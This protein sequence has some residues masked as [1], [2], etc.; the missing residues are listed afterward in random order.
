MSKHLSEASDGDGDLGHESVGSEGT[1][2]AAAETSRDMVEDGFDIATHGGGRLESVEGFDIARAMTEGFES[3]LMP[4]DAAMESLPRSCDLHY[5]QTPETVCGRDDRVQITGTS[6]I[7]WRMICQL[8]I[9][10]ADNLQSRCTGWF[11][12][13]RTVVTAGHCVFSKSAGG[14]AKRIEVIPGMNGSQRPFGSAVGTSFRSVTGW[15]NDQSPDYDYGAIILPN[16]TLGN[17]VGWFGFANLSDSSLKELLVNSSG[18][19][20]D[21]PFGTQWYNAGRVTRMTNRRIFYMLDTTGGNSGGPI[22]RNKDGVRHA[23]GVHAYGGCPNSAVR[24][25][26]PVFDRLKAW[27]ALGS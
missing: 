14:W 13:P 1:A 22:W 27:K 11:I 3:E 2:A 26:K 15:T 12:G 25:T 4:V 5:G 18:Y 21:K 9:T 8:I 10:R 6:A 20:G 16:N 17:V 7:P 24:I 19:S 23:V